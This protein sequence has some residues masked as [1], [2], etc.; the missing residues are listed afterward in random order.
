[1][2]AIAIS[3]FGGRDKLQLMELPL[4]EVGRNEIL[5][6]VG[7]AGANPVDWE[8]REAYLK[9]NCSPDLRSCSTVPV[10]WQRL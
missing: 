4:P 7:A 9:E 1:M 6:R 3:E 2:K 10:C 5:V 8:I